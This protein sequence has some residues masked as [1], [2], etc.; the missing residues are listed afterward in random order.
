M[1]SPGE[2]T[3]KVLILD[4]YT[5]VSK[6]LFNKSLTTERRLAEIEIMKKKKKGSFL[7]YI[8]LHYNWDL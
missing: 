7:E 8:S 5:K 4:F 1:N 2:F 6:G 3:S